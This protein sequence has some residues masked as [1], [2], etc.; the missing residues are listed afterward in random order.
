MAEIRNGAGPLLSMNV[1]ASDSRVVVHLLGELDLSTAPLLQATLADV[2]GDQ[3]LEIVLD[4]ADLSYID[5]TGLSL[6]ITTTKRAH[7][8]G[9]KV[10]LQDPQLSTQRLLEITNLTD[11][12]DSDT[13]AR[14]AARGNH[15][16]WAT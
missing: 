2:L 16:L 4:L 5:S 7:A 3:A 10:I 14:V 13:K 12:F 11:Y 15:P 9:S 6:F 8:A 1:E